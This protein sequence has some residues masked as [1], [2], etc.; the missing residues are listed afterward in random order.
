M[1]ESARMISGGAELRPEDLPPTFLSK[2]G[3]RRS[4]GATPVLRRL[5]AS[6]HGRRGRPEKRLTPEQI[7]EALDATGGS[8]TA[9]AARLG[10]SRTTLWRKIAEIGERL[11]EVPTPSGSADGP[12]E[13]P[14]A[15][16]GGEET[17]QR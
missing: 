9:A 17:P 1:A 11:F 10:V 16:D 14:D 13:S 12:E 8:R 5:P 15:S 4:I 6:I 3:D 2:A 7:R